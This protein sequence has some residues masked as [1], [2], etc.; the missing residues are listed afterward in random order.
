MTEPHATPEA[1]RVAL[2][3]I[4]DSREVT[5][6]MW[7]LWVN[8]LKTQY[9]MADRTITA[10]QLAKANGLSSHS[11]ANTRYNSLAH[12]IG[13][14]LGYTPPNHTGGA[15]KPM[16]WMMLSTGQNGDY[17]DEGFQFTLRPELAQAL[18]QMRWVQPATATM[19]PA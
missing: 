19:T 5:S 11:I 13:D 2:L 1:Y 6:A 7:E 18:E 17:G 3:T 16:W 15:R 8:L 12:A 14:Q 9:Q 10:T 4:R